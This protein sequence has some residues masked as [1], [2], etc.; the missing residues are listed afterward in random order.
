MDGS[1]ANASHAMSRMPAG[2]SVTVH[3]PFII[4][5]WGD[6]RQGDRQGP[7]VPDSRVQRSC[8]NQTKYE[9]T[10][11]ATRL[12]PVDGPS[13]SDGN[14][15]MMKCLPPITNNKVGFPRLTTPFTPCPPPRVPFVPL[16]VSPSRSVYLR[17][18]KPHAPPT[19]STAPLSET[20]SLRRHDTA[21]LSPRPTITTC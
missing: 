14:L 9:S 12:E 20:R 8:A 21:D 2:C 1:A 11:A 3:R 7:R 4:D 19:A 6:G 13:H 17:V 5:Q 10:L 16:S 15:E 18:T